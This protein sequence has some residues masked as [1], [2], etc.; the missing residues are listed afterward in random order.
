[1]P[2]LTEVLRADS[3]RSEGVHGGCGPQNVIDGRDASSGCVRRVRC[4]I[5]VCTT[6]VLH[7]QS[8]HNMYAASTG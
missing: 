4:V 6:D 3:G 5:R 1:V 7:I 8:V 2:A